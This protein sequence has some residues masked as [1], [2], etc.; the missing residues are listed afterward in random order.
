VAYNQ[1]NSIEQPQHLV[2][3]LVGSDL[4]SDILISII[5]RSLVSDVA[6]ALF[7]LYL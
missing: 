3:L 6:F 4:M 5:Y 7:V 1:I 2:P